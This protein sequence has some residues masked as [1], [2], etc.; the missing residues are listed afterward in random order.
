MSRET[1]AILDF[2]SQYLQLIARR[3][4]EHQ[5]HSL[6][7]A[8]DVSPEVLRA[9]DVIGIILSG[10]PASAYGEAAP[11]AHAGILDLGVPILGI[12][13]GMQVA[14][15]A[16]GASVVAGEQG[17]YGR[18]RLDVIASDPLVAHIP[19]ETSVWMSHGDI[20]T[21]Y[22]DTFTVL[23]RTRNC[24]SAVVRHRDRPLYGAQFHPE[25]TH[26]PE[27]SRLLRNFLYEVCGAAGTWNPG[28]IID[29]LIGGIRTR[30]LVPRKIFISVNLI[31]HV[32]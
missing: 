8:P 30:A 5:V 31:G 26:T 13:Y 18:T 17:E 3:V 28:S 22:G 7:F 24:P 15:Q 16:L 2:G 6:I 4:R 14:C 20:V 19:K 23:A 29:D 9:H 1:I 12:C 11:R 21:D 10:G 27:G 25:V 32:Q